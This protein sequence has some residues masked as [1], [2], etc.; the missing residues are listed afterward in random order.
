LNAGAYRQTQFRQHTPNN[1]ESGIAGKHLCHSK[2][3]LA[4]GTHNWNRPM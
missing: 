2:A 3:L 4:W 1:R